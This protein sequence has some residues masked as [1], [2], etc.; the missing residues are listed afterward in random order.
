MNGI[1]HKDKLEESQGLP[2]S[3]P[4]ALKNALFW[5]LLMNATAVTLVNTNAAPDAGAV[6]AAIRKTASA[7]WSWLVAAADAYAA[8]AAARRA[9]ERFMAAAI[10][11]PR[12]M[13]ELNAARCR[14]EQG[15]FDAAL[16]PFVMEAPA[17]P[18]KRPF[19]VRMSAPMAAI[20]NN[21]GR[22]V[23]LYYI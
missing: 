1:H 4:I 18:K 8:R 12:I 10:A 17:V 23:N 3:S 5:S 19:K 13:A 9:D 21:S 2:Y 11:D 7:T 14:A 16:A 20:T 22:R 6:V 15:D